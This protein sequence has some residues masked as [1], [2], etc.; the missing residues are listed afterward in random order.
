MYHLHHFMP[1]CHD[2][3]THVVAHVAHVVGYLV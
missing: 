1:Y 2:V 3:L